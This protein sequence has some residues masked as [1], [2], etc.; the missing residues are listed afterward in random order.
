M[1]YIISFPGQSS[2]TLSLEDAA[3]I[4]ANRGSQA[5]QR[6]RRKWALEHP[7]ELG[8]LLSTFSWDREVSWFAVKRTKEYFDMSESTVQLVKD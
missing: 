4:Y 8:E 2:Y 5:L 1:Y 3:H 6:S 7:T